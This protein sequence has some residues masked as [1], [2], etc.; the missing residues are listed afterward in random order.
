MRIT[1][2]LPCRLRTGAMLAAA[3]GT[4]ALSGVSLSTVVRFGAGGRGSADDLPGRQLAGDSRRWFRL[5]GAMRDHLDGHAGRWDQARLA[6]HRREQVLRRDLHRAQPEQLPLADPAPA[7]CAAHALLR[8]RPLQHGQLHL[9]RLR[10]GPV[11]RR[12]GRLLDDGEHDQQQQ[13]DHHDRHGRHRAPTP[14]STADASG[15]VH[16]RRRPRPA[17]RTAT[18]ASCSC[19]AASTPRSADNG[20]V[21][22]TDVPT[23]FNQFNAAGV[24]WKAY[25]QDLGGAQPVG[26]TTYVTGSTPGVTDTVPAVTTARAATRARRAPTRSRIRPTWSRRAATSRA[27]PAPSRRADHADHRQR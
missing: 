24:S 3:V 6:D 21:Y 13:R 20:C 10:S 12:A 17:P 8:H 26:S 4:F 15:H 1:G 18:T 11:L 19:T 22:P 25:A 16:Q 7:G 27:S 5:T 23:L 9:A 14:T 2:I